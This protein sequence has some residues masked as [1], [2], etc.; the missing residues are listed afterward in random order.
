M[1]AVLTYADINR[2]F[3][4]VVEGYIRRGYVINTSTI[5]SHGNDIAH[6]DVTNGKEVVRI[7]LRGFHERIEFDLLNGLEVIAGEV[8]ADEVTPNGDD[9]LEIIWN[10]HL[11]EITRDRF[12]AIES[13]YGSKEYALYSEKKR[14]ARMLRKNEQESK[15]HVFD[16]DRAYR[17]AGLYIRRKLGKKRVRRSDT[18]IYRGRD[19][20]RYVIV[21]CNKVY[22]L[23]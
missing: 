10:D 22:V 1:S 23:K 18:K 17:I 16:S 4:G 8:P 20:G 7:L 12:Y 15:P 3:T 14:Y 9:E 6:V 5:G 2:E 13:V 11:S 21:H 19:Y